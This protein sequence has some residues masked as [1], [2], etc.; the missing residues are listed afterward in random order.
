MRPSTPRKELAVFPWRVAMARPSFSLARKRSTRWRL[1]QS[2]DGPATGAPRCSWAGRRTCPKTP[3]ELTQGRRG[4][5][6][7][8]NDP[9]RD[10]GEE[11]HEQRRKRQPRRPSCRRRRASGQAPHA[12]RAADPPLGPPLPPPSGGPGCCWPPREKPSPSQRR[13]AGMWRHLAPFSC[14]QTI[15]SRVRRRLWCAVS[16]AGRHASINGASTARG[17][18]SVSTRSSS[19]SNLSPTGGWNSG[20]NRPRPA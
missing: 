9:G 15:A 2:H 16:G 5:A 13:R 11:G 19:R 18:A 1:G 3:D 7:V 17:G 12:R 4:A 8:G 20:T 14:R 10:P 6:A